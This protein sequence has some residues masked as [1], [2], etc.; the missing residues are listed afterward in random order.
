MNRMESNLQLVS[1]LKA[2]VEEYP[3]LRFGQILS[4]FGFVKSTSPTVLEAMA[5]QDEY[6]L[7]PEPLIERVQL[8]IA[9][10]KHEAEDDGA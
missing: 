6:Y 10:I 7:E 5:W 4:S 1:T 3:T 8:A 2:L 9:R